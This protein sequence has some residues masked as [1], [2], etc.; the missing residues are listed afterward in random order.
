MPD[1]PPPCF[2]L[3]SRREV[4]TTDAANGRLAEHWQTDSPSLQYAHREIH[5]TER[6]RDMNPTPS[7]LYRE[8]MQQAQPYVIRSQ[9]V[10]EQERET[11]LDTKSAVALN[12]IESLGSALASTLNPVEQ[13]KIRAELG[14]QQ[15]LYSLYMKQRKQLNTDSLTRNPY[16]DKYDV[17]GDSRNIIRELR[18]VV[19]E[20]IVD[21]GMAESQKLLRRGMENRWVPPH[22]AEKEGLDSLT[23]YELMKPKFNVQDKVYFN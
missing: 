1:L 14:V 12:A 2:S 7:R 3:R 6:Y 18:S 9:N 23:A 10:S 22:F 15:E 19:S 20:G 13:K 21:R 17:Q 8:D 16:F 5:G 11:D 4:N